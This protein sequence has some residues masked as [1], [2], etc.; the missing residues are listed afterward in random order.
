M[1][2]INVT[3]FLGTSALALFAFIFVGGSLIY[4]VSLIIAALRAAIERASLLAVRLQR[5]SSDLSRPT[6]LKTASVSLGVIL[7]AAVASTVADDTAALLHAV[8]APPVQDVQARSSN[9]AKV[10][11]EQPSAQHRLSID[12]TDTSGMRPSTPRECAPNQGIVNECT[13]N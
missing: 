4:S 3:L 8:A 2:A 13:F 1:S 11:E 10:S 5:R 9:A 7:A 12:P 6:W